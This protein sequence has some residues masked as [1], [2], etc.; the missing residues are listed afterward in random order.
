M[1]D[2]FLVQSVTNC[3]EGRPDDEDAMVMSGR[4][5]AS[6]WV[7]RGR[8]MSSRSGPFYTLSTLSF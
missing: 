6:R 4:V 1:R 3:E 8:L 5:L 2:G 7:M